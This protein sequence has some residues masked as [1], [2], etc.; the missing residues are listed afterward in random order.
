[1]ECWVYGSNPA[2]N[3]DLVGDG[4]LPPQSRA[5]LCETNGTS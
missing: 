3:G 5:E 1:M 2:A 4:H